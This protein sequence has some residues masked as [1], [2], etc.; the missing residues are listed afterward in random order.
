MIEGVVKYLLPA[1]HEAVICYNDPGGCPLYFHA[2]MEGLK[3]GD[4][5]EI[6]VKKKV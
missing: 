5:V 3:E 2:S 6:T 4:K 1:R